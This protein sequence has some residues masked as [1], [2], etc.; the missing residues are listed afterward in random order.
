MWTDAPLVDGQTVAEL[1]ACVNRY[2]VGLARTVHLGTPPDDLLRTSD[3]VREGM[4]A[5]MGALKAGTAGD[6]HAAWLAVL[7]R[8]GLEKA[9]RIGYSIGA[10]YAPDWGEL[11]CPFAGM[12]SYS[13]GKCRCACDPSMDG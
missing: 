4:A 2:N 12:A 1:G 11:R 13:A 7:S 5:V 3:A 10:A 8:Y 6:V 9:S